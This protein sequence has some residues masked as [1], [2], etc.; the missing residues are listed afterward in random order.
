[1]KARSRFALITTTIAA[2]T[3]SAIAS[4]DM[5]STGG[6]VSF[7]VPGPL[8]MT[9]SGKSNSLSATEVGGKVT[10]TIGF[11]CGGEPCFDTDS[12]L[13]NKHLVNGVGKDAAVFTIDKSKLSIPEDGKT[14]TGSGV[15]SLLLH[16]VK[17]DAQAMTYKISR[18]GNDYTVDGKTTVYLDKHKIEVKHAGIGPKNDVAVTLHFVLHET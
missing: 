15:G 9:I 7:T 11:V 2:L 16:G 5:K 13:R 3:L 8:G 6:N 17:N 12:S 4:A 10:L 18:K 1:M 14:T